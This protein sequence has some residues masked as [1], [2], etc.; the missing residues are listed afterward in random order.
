MEFRI[1]GPVEARGSVGP[2][3]LPG[4]RQPALLAAL[5]LDANRVV[6]VERLAEALWDDDPPVNAA[7]AM[8]TYVFRVRQALA[9]AEPDGDQRLTFAAGYRLRVEPGELDLDAFRELAR[10]GRAC[11]ETAAADFGAA[12]GLW[13]GVAL[14]GVPGRNLAAHA[15]R[16]A[17]ERLA[18]L[19]E[20]I[21][22]DLAEGRHTELVAELRDLVAE[23]PLRERLHGH[24]MLALC[25]A[26]RPAEAS[27][28]FQAVRAALADELGID[29]GAEIVELHQR[30]LR[31][32]VGAAAAEGRPAPVRAGPRNDL[33]G[34]ILDFTGR[35][36]ELARLLA[37]LPDRDDPAGTVVIE[38]IDG[39]AGVGKTTLAVHAAHRLVDR[40]PDAQLFIDL[41]GHTTEREATDPAAAL[42]ILLR[43]I[44]V[45]GEQVPQELDQRAAL[46][47][48][49]L[50]DRRALVVLDNA[51]SAAQVRPLL[52]GAAGCL[53]LITSRRRL[54]DLDAAR[55]LSLDVLPPEQAIALFD[56]VAGPDD[57][58]GPG[59][60]TGPDDRT[61]PSGDADA[62]A[63]AEVVELCG[64]LPL[65]IR[66]AAARLR[67]R[68]A[69]TAAH[70]AG[71]LREGRRRLREL[72]TGDRSV[73][74]AFALS[75]E[76]LDAAQQRMFQLL[77]L[78]P[79]LDFDAAAAASLAAVDQR[80]AELL[81]EGLVDVHLLAE[82]AP[83][84]Y[85][86]HDLLRQHAN[87]TA[88][89]EEPEAER[90]QALRRLTDFYVH[91]A[92]IG[93]H[94]LEPHRPQ[95]QLDEPAP[96]CRP[97]PMTDQAEAMAWFDAEHACLLAVQQAALARGAHPP[98]WQ[99]AWTL[100]TYHHRRGHAHDQLATWQA[101]LA[102][103]TEE[104]DQA[105]QLR[106]H[107]MLGWTLSRSGQH[108][109]ATDQL[110]R[111]L[112]LAEDTGDRPG[113]AHTHGALAASWDQREGYE[114][115]LRHSAAA[116]DLYLALG[117]PTGQVRAQAAVGWY[118]TK[119]G[120][121]DRAQAALDEALALCRQLG[122]QDTEANILDSLGHL[123]HHTGEH[124]RA[125]DH[126]GRARTLRHDLGNTY[127]EANTV[128]RL[129]E[130][131]L[132]LG[133][134]D[135]A[136]DAWR[137]ALALYEAQRR[138]KDVERVRSKLADLD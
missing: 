70:L 108:A 84:R 39:M 27:R 65:A 110:Q 90:R 132:A 80:D 131:R 50:A 86:F 10:R 33:P 53:A 3:W 122:I 35:D 67:T 7:S 8:Q 11:A 112:A 29:P 1:L 72:A 58:T 107:R 133:R 101:G 51:A 73:A 55:T 88:L 20:R 63:V 85:R 43:A 71:R 81:L 138:T 24:L 117:D 68:P 59:G 69:W 77:G 12:L 15:A 129:A 37:A 123:A 113:Q 30:I 47:R 98:V 48:A 4:T 40:F 78:H 14:L 34:D 22:A 94:T 28:V 52:P 75:Y 135:E 61:G 125:L 26:G 23:H 45:S 103:A 93:D 128:D 87:A 54:A 134:P 92:Q 97:R 19:E 76:H 31:G 36:A 136:R 96:G 100:G 13:R 16:L 79:G 119:L 60:D 6:P 83:G 118:L 5:L 126:Y 41:H 137:Q 102:A 109:E 56:R 82:P 105:A 17:E 66:I 111:A 25:R 57:G 127:H 121:Y 106:A 91:T 49:E 21:A 2:V 9:A 42:D 44:G 64:Y 99:L 38:A 89:A 62:A 130:T 18:V 104:R 120:N 114:P 115:A 74:A 116:L 32:D 95:L 46:W 124:A